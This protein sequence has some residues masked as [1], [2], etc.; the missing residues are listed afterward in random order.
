MKR[1]VAIAAA[2]MLLLGVA[3]ST[4]ESTSSQSQD[5][6]AAQTQTSA[7]LQTPTQNQSAGASLSDSSAPNAVVK[8]VWPSVVRIRAGGQQ[9]GPFG[10]ISRGEGTGTGFIVDSRGYVVT[11]NHVVTLGTNRE[12]NRLQVDLW[13]GRTVDATLVGRDERTDLAVLKINADNL[14]PVRFADTTKT[15]IGEPVLA[16]GFAL[17]LGSTPT[18]TKGVVSAKDRVINE[19]LNAGGSAYPISISGAIQ[20]DAAIN[21]GNS[22]GPLVN[23]R[24]E[25]VGVNTAGLVGSAGQP[26]QGIFFAVSAQVAEPIVE[27]LMKD[28]QV[29]RGFLGVEVVSVT[30]QLAQS[31]NLGAQ[32]GAGIRTVTSGSAA[33]R[34][35]LRAGDVITK[36]GDHSVKNIGD[37]SNA[38]AAYR[39]GQKVK[40][41]Y[42]RGGAAASTDVTLAERPAGTT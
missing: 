33:D 15:E 7:A 27:A 23:M 17:D 2:A 13:D 14:T 25:V 31:E 21:P 32:E 11:N 12:V 28:G 41:E 16:L 26:V 24:G 9:Q 37:V 30:P 35:G 8:A 36:I 22:G 19:T 6:A 4:E 5:A 39:P 3:C 18:V 42:V 40:V 10:T 29:N 1:Y 34:A 20:T 38:L